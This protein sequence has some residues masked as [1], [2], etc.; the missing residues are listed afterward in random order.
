MSDSNDAPRDDETDARG[1]MVA[2]IVAGDRVVTGI[3][4]RDRPSTRL[5]FGLLVVALGVILLLDQLGVA[6]ASVILRWWPALTLAYGLMLLTGICSRR[7]PIAGILVSFFS[8]W[9]L[10]ERLDILHRSPWDLWPLVLVVI[11]AAMVIAALR[12]HGSAVAAERG[13][14]T[15]RAF[16]LFSGAGRK[17]VSEDFRGGEI[18][19]IMGGH[20]VD[21][22]P[23]KI[24]EGP[25][26]IDVFI[27]WG[28]VDLRVPEDWKVTNEALA[29]L[30]GVDDKTRA[31][32]G[33]VKGH[34]VIR[35]LIVMG[36]MDVRN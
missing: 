34:L 26:V 4:L 36:G 2:G 10:L 31:P 24:A 21:L 5:V 6:D 19:A 30:G 1:K 16:A 17:V 35:G 8:G 15:L 14:S 28:G 12:G 22:R 7:S 29:L 3:V 11:G 33:E 23:A 25:A 13:A 18:T 20:D 27:W 32:E 9:L